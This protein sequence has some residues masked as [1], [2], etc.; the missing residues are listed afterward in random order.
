[1]ANKIKAGIVG[2]AGY[3]GGETI[4]LLLHHPQVDLV[5]V[6]SRSNAGNT[7]SQVHA[8]LI[9]ETNLKFTDSVDQHVD[10]IFALVTV[11]ARN[12]CRRTKSITLFQSLT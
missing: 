6:Q 7:I 4:W 8:D 2:G 9:G 11:K 3:T 10:V 5:F 12:F 1:M